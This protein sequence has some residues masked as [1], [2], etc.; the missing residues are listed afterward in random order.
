MRARRLLIEIHGGADPAADRREAR[1]ALTV[2]DLCQEHLDAAHAGLVLTR[3][4]QRKASSTISNEVGWINRHVLPLIGTI[5]PNEL[6]R[7]IVQKMH[8]AIASGQTSGDFK[9]RRG[10]RGAG[11]GWSD[12]RRLSVCGDAGRHLDMG[13]KALASSLDQTRRIVSKNTSQ[14]HATERSMQTN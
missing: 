2:A 3:R 1:K 11:Q 12:R 7:P 13:R 14:S 10:G 8:D 6:T 9:T 4:R 5:P